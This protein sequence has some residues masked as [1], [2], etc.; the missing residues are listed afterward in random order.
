MTEQNT[1]REELERIRKVSDALCSGHASLRD[2]YRRRALVLDLAILFL[3]TWLVAVAFVSPE[4]SAKLNPLSV[5][6]QIWIG[7]LGI[8]TFLLTLLQ[9]KTDWKSQADA[10]KRTVDL[11]AEVKREAGYV[12]ASGELDEFA[13]R[14]VLSRYDMASAVGIPM[15]ESEFLRQKR[16]HRIKVAL[17]KHLDA[18]PSASILVTRLRWWLRDNAGK[19]A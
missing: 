2:R 13:C 6:S 19:G 3:T 14:R 17:S 5:D 9:L 18:H 12:L 4:M 11:Y 8:G 16:R 10:H 7:F 1:M 15:P